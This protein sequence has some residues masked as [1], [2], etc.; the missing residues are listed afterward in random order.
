M[1]LHLNG[2]ANRK[3]SNI[4]PQ[5]VEGWCRVALSDFIKKTEYLPSKFEIRYSIF[6]IRFLQFLFLIRL[7]VVLASGRAARPA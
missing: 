2:T 5:N 1:K 4:E 6:D 7:A 3:I